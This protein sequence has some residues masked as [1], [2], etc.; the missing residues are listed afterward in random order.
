MNF[1]PE[2]VERYPRGNQEFSDQICVDVEDYD[3]LLALYRE[4][5]NELAR[6]GHGDTYDLK[7]PPDPLPSEVC[8]Y[9]DSN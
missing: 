2:K 1:D 8:A 6:R 5:V 9:M 4:A 3:A 7:H